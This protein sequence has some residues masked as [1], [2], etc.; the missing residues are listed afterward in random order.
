MLMGLL[1]IAHLFNSGASTSKVVLIRDDGEI[2]ALID[3][4]LPSTNLLVSINYLI[5]NF[6]LNLVSLNIF[7]SSIFFA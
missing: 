1:L 3:D 7:V 5:F 4:N 2:L 6:Y